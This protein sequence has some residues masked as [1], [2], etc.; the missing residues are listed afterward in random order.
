[1]RFFLLGHLDIGSGPFQLVSRLLQVVTIAREGLAQPCHAGFLV[2][3]LGLHSRFCRCHMRASPSRLL[4]GVPF[5]AGSSSIVLIPPDGVRTSTHFLDRVLHQRSRGSNFPL[6]ISKV[7]DMN[8]PTF[9]RPS[10]RAPNCRPKQVRLSVRRV[11]VRAQ[12]FYASV[13]IG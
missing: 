11:S 12:R 7:L 1:M 8:C 3:F 10:Y 4:P 9:L 5:S 13:R 6:L 2:L